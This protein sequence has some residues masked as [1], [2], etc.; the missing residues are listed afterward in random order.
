MI[1]LALLFPEV[2]WL[3]CLRFLLFTVT[4][5]RVGKQDVMAICTGELLLW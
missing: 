4:Y 2:E 5:T 3:F 1:F